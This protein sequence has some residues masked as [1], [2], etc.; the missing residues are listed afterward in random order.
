[1][2]VKWGDQ[3]IEA[4]PDL[5]IMIELT[6]KDRENISNMHAD[7]TRYACFDD[8]D[9]TTTE[10]KL[11]WMNAGASFEAAATLIMEPATKAIGAGEIEAFLI[12]LKAKEGE[13]WEQAKRSPNLDNWFVGQA[14]KHFG[15]K[16]NPTTVRELIYTMMQ[17]ES[18]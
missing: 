2:R 13:K 15:G 12:D 7:A 10:E 18:Q 14:M 17:E 5:P 11:A 6:K 9:T 4:K 3:W 1:M 8:A 16:P